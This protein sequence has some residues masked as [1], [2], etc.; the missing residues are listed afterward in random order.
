MKKKPS[1]AAGSSSKSTPSKQNS[2]TAAIEVI[3][4]IQNLTDAQLESI[5]A[6]QRCSSEQ[7]LLTESSHVNAVTACGEVAAIGQTLMLDVMI[8]GE[9]VEAMVDSGSQ[10]TIISRE[11]LH[12]VGR[13]LN[14]QGKPL[15][16]FEA[17][18]GI[19]LWGKD[20]KY[21]LDITA[22]VTLTM[23]AGGKAVKV[24]VFLQ[25]DS[26]QPCLLGMNAAPA[27]GISF[28]DAHDAALRQQS[29]LSSPHAKVRLVQASV[30]LGQKGLFL[31]GQ[32]KGSV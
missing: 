17:V 1:E 12:R 13:R 23:E 9:P 30:V 7:S 8:E 4:P 29:P 14:R 28:L 16:L 21:Q 32:I 6:E 19:K 20:G 22:K 25:P 10:N 2:R 26:Q 3:D 5:L 27:L 31:E 11:T 18:S 24:P 15:P